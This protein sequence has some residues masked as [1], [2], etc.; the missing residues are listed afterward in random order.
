M[1]ITKFSMK[2]ICEEIKLRFWVVWTVAYI[3][4]TFTWP[5]FEK[6]IFPISSFRSCLKFRILFK[7]RFKIL[8]HITTYISRIFNLTYLVHLLLRRWNHACWRQLSHEL[9]ILFRE[10]C[11]DVHVLD[12]LFTYRSFNVNWHG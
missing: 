9:E 8:I 4:K 5:R 2:I 11:L 10:L 6:K 1:S 12:V 7:R 3:F